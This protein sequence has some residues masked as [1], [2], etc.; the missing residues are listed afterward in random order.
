MKKLLRVVLPLFL[1]AGCDI[2]IYE[3]PY[4]TYD[5]RDLF[6]GRYQVEEY[7]Q[8]TGRFF[9]YAFV[10]SKSCCDPTGVIITNF[11]GSG[12]AVYATVAGTQLTIPWQRIEGYETEGTGRITADRLTLTYFV[13]DLYTR[14]VVTDFV[15]AE[16]W[17]Y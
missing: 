3:E 9:R 1:L 8:T 17:L 10:V 7:S 13:R 2:Y 14:P 15:D 11:Y 16:A 5:D 4:V 6:V 12:L